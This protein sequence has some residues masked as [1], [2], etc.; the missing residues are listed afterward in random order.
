MYSTG[1]YMQYL[2][3]IYNGK[4]SEKLYMY[5]NHFS[6]HLKLNIVNQ[7]YFN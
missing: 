4:E 3:I 1:N 2:I 6:V 7:L 5:I